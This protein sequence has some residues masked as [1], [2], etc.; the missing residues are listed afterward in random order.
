M[1]LSSVGS[2]IFNS[3]SSPASTDKRR[4]EE[5]MLVGATMEEKKYNTT[6]FYRTFYTVEKNEQK[7]KQ[8]VYVEVEVHRPWKS[9]TELLCSFFLRLY[10]TLFFRYVVFFLSFSLLNDSRTND[11]RTNGKKPTGTRYAGIRLN[12]YFSRLPVF[13]HDVTP[14][15]PRMRTLVAHFRIVI[16]QFFGLGYVRR[17]FVNLY[18]NSQTNAD[19]MSIQAGEV[20][21]KND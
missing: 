5:R 17:R 3:T 7:K 9:C 20:I 19:R 13:Q 14:T 21:D 11:S 2:Y 1:K 12:E 15:L 6:S 18:N 10:C 16:E 8:P 4:H